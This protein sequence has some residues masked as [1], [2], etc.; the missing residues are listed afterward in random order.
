MYIREYLSVFFLYPFLFFFFALL[1]IDFPLFYFIRFPLHFI[2]FPSFFRCLLGRE[3]IR[4]GGVWNSNE[5]MINDA[6]RL[7]AV[8]T[9]I[10]RAV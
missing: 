5:I 8:Y 9:F 1:Y 2:Y 3:G 7:I 4:G 6:S 10:V